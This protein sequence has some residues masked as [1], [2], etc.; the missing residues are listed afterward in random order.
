MD[1]IGIT[2]RLCLP[3]ARPGLPAGWTP[4]LPALPSATAQ[5][6]WVFLS[7]PLFS[8]KCFLE[9]ST[10]YGITKTLLARTGKSLKVGQAGKGCRQRKGSRWLPQT[11]S[12]GRAGAPFCVRSQASPHRLSDGF[13]MFPLLWESS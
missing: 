5:Q 10:S 9:G 3:Q 11:R 8:I 13:F 4:R 1:V 12:H 7:L 6:C 2:A